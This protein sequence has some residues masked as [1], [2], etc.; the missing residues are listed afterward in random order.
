MSGASVTITST[1]GLDSS[2]DWARW[3]QVIVK[4]KGAA[5]ESADIEEFADQNSDFGFELRILSRLNSMGLV[6]EH[7]GTYDDPATNKPRQFDIRATIRLAVECKYLRANFP[8]VIST[9]PKMESESFHELILSHRPD[10]VAIP[11]SAR[12]APA[13]SMKPGRLAR[14]EDERSLYQPGDHVGKSCAQVGRVPS[15]EL[16]SVDNHKT[17]MMRA[18]S[19]TKPTKFLAVFSYRVATRRNCLMRPKNRSTRFRCL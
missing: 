12:I 5:I 10:S 1:I 6:C 11:I 3:R 9:V 8:L 18:A 19:Q 2:R 7:G 17:S 16:G 13:M 14:I 15:G 4:L